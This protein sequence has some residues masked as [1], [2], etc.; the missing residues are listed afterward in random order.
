MATVA[1][2]S[3]GTT[4][5]LP[6]GPTR[7]TE[8]AP[9]HDRISATASRCATSS[10]SET[11][12]CRAAAIDS[13]FGVFTTI[14]ANRGEPRR[15]SPPCRALPIDSP[16]DGLTQSTQPAYSTGD[17]HASSTTDPEWSTT[18]SSAGEAPASR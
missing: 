7:V 17:R 13:D 3:T 8:C 2:R 9:S 11:S 12:G 5:C 16:L 6:R 18:A 10:A 4:S 14:S 1:S 15:P